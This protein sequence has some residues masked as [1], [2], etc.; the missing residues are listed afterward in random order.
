MS[1]YFN[2]NGY[3]ICD[4]VEGNP[5]GETMESQVTVKTFGFAKKDTRHLEEE[6]S[7]RFKHKQNGKYGRR[8]F[9]FPTQVMD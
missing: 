1:S 7:L 6:I 5:C 4:Y 3:V 2:D 9:A 8:S